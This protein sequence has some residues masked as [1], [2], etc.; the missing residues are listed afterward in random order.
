MVRTRRSRRA[1]QLKLVGGIVLGCAVLA[2]VVA[3]LIYRAEAGRSHVRLN[4]ENQCPLDGPR[5][6]TVVVVDRTDPISPT[7]ALALTNELQ[8]VAKRVPQYGALHMYAIDGAITGVA[9]PVFFRCNPGSEE[10]VNATTGSKAK[11]KRRFEEQFSAPLQAAIK[12]LTSARQADA[13]PIMEGIQGAALRALSSPEA[14]GASPKRLIIASDFMQNSDA[15]SFYGRSAS[16]QLSAPDGL[17]APLSGV[18]VGLMFIQR[19]NRPGPSID[20][21]KT[22]WTNYFV[23][24]GVASNEVRSIRLTGV[25]P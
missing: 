23:Q 21:L 24:S 14:K 17:D 4:A 6:V 16:Q 9:E 13:S 15:V 10:N 20:A 8:L 1:D 5:S 22:A 19:P 18:E 3:F 25:S 2:P 11:A 7:T 12:T